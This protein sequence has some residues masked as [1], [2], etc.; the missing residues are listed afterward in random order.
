MSEQI[1]GRYTIVEE[2]GSGGMGTVYRAEDRLTGQT[3][4]LKRVLLN[5]D[6]QLTDSLAPH[7]TR[8]QMRM[9]LA[10]EFQLMAGLRHPHIISVLDY[11]F[12]TE[13]QPFYTMTYLPESQTILEAGAALDLEGKINLIQQLLQGLA[14]LHRRGILH[15]DIKPENVLIVDGEVKLL[16]FGLS[17]SAEEEGEMGGSP[18]YMAPELFNGD[19]PTR[20]SDLYAVGILLYQLLT[21]QHPFGRFDTGFYRRVLTRA[22]DLSEIDPVLQPIL[23]RLI[24]RRAEQRYQKG[25]DPLHDIA[26]A[27]GHQRPAES[28]TIRESY[29]QAAQFVGRR[30]ESETLAAALDKAK[31]GEGSAWLLGG[32]SGVGKSRLLRELQPQALVRGFQLLVGQSIEEGGG[33]GDPFHIWREPLR[34][35]LLLLP[36]VD[37]LTA[38]VLR[39]LIPDIEQLL[40]RPIKPAPVLDDKAAQLRLFTTIATLFWQ[41]QRPLL[42]I[43]EDIHWESESLLP[44]TYLNELINEYPVVIIGSYR[45]DERPDLPQ[46]LPKMKTVQL[47]RLTADEMEALSTAMLG[48][49]GHN[50][51]IVDLIQRETEGNTFFAVEIV[52]ALAEEAGNLA[53]ITTIDLPQTL[54][55]RGIQDIVQR[56]LNKLPEWAKPLLIRA[57]VI[58]LELDLTLLE[59]ITEEI[60]PDPEI[61]IQNR[62]LPLCADAA[63][64]EV[65][66]GVWQFA[67]GKIRDGLLAELEPRQKIELHTEVAVT[68]EQLFP[69]DPT[70][71]GRLASHWQ[72]AENAAKE[73]YY[74]EIAGEQAAANFVHADAV[75]YFERALAL[76]ERLDIK[77]EIQLHKAII[78]VCDLNGD[79]E[80]HRESLVALS[81]LNK[82]QPDPDL[83]L[84]RLDLL[85]GWIQ[86]FVKT[87]QVSEL[88]KIAPEAVDLAQSC[89]DLDAE[90]TILL[91]WMYI[92]CITFKFDDAFKHLEASRLICERIGTGEAHKKYVYHA[93]TFHFFSGNSPQALTY[94]LEHLRLCEAAAEED[95]VGLAVSTS[96]LAGAYIKM[97]EYDRCWHYL[98]RALPL[99]HKVGN[100]YQEGGIHHNT[101]ILLIFL[102]LYEQGI[103]SIKKAGRIWKQIGNRINFAKS[104]TTLGYLY[105]KDG[106]LQAARKVLE[107]GLGLLNEQNGGQ[108]TFGLGWYYL[109]CL[110]IDLGENKEALA[111]LRAAEAT[112]TDVSFNEMVVEIW[113]G[114][115]LALLKNDQPQAAVGYAEKVWEYIQANG[116]DEMT[117][118]WDWAQ[119]SV[120]ISTV[121]QHVGDARF[122]D[123]IRLAHHTL[124]T[125]AAKIA[126]PEIRHSYLTNFVEHPQIS[127]LYESLEPTPRG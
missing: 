91:D 126:D 31:Q 11:G 104:F 88:E 72:Q 108:P 60:V 77:K 56:R 43:L 39:P 124:Q 67:H 98:R 127:A 15:R 123:V 125:R 40:G 120:Q 1:N 85:Q 112:T 59:E 121:F 95:P 70:Q 29:L 111:L 80:K 21:R 27:L 61:D 74:A 51:K 5:P 58:G 62:W 49:A 100:I 89:G 2:I 87:G 12:D 97:G 24:S 122:E 79:T 6:L 55:P 41:A 22:P 115:G 44:L 81:A 64:F 38:G 33:S 94:R 50:Q 101:A 57:A 119:V 71:A 73:G 92:L 16:D 37:D 109:G 36:Q 7:L 82:Q 114:L 75:R 68:L 3:V 76:A 90:A 14:Y 54:L 102:G 86:F 52:R 48:E 96:N 23:G 19:E 116:T 8:E 26:Q 28:D 35:L 99:A 20:A 78:D 34:H 110:L 4:A 106:Q 25:G 30:T 9:V 17:H 42:L 32:E 53:D 118:D 69:D 93:G 46:R 66:H 45:S 83:G 13:K 105:H 65:Q 107:T 63:I 18:L 10:K 47:A 84:K 117:G 113:A 103:E